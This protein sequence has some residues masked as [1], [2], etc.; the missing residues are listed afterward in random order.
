MDTYKKRLVR[1]QFDE[2]LL[3]SSEKKIPSQLNFSALDESKRES[4]DQFN[5]NNKKFNVSSSYSEG[6]YTTEIDYK[7]LSDDLV[8][9]AQTLE[10]VLKLQ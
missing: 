3:L 7:N 5:L 9:R 10:N 8:Q 2:S 1:S 6:Q 4:F